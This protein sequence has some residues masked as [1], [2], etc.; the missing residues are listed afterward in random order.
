MSK[1]PANGPKEK[2]VCSTCPLESW[3]ATKKEVI[4]FCAAYRKDVWTTTGPDTVMDCDAR[5]QAL[6]ALEEKRKEAAQSRSG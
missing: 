4:C 3:Y 2:P 6:D 1:N 5:E